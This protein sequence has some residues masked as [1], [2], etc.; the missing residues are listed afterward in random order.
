MAVSHLDE[1]ANELIT[2]GICTEAV[3]KEH[4]VWEGSIDWSRIF[5]HDETP[6]FVNYGVDGTANGLVYSGK[7]EL[8]QKM[9]RENRECVTIH[10]FVSLAGDIDLCHVIFKGKGIKSH[11]APKVAI[12]KIPNLLISTT[13]IGTQDHTSLLAAYKQFY[14]VLT[15]RNLDQWLFYLMDILHVLTVI[16]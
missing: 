7:G 14:K 8:C 2:C 11:M 1:L 4:G 10:P 16:F 6:Q 12:T 5:N 3:Q 9:L 15:E 13:D